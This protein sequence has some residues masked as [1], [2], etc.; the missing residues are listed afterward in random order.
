MWARGVGRL[1]EASHVGGRWWQSLRR[2]GRRWQSLVPPWRHV[3]QVGGGSGIHQV[4]PET[5]KVSI[6]ACK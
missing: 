1:L 6:A 3:A 5:L 4:I 2:V